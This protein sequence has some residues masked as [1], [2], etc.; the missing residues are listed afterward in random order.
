MMGTMTMYSM[1]SS[2]SA[3]HTMTST[4]RRCESGVLILS[5]MDCTIWDRSRL[6]TGMIM[7]AG[8]RTVAGRRRRRTDRGVV[9]RPS[10]P[11]GEAPSAVWDCHGNHRRVDVAGTR[12]L[13]RTSKCASNPLAGALTCSHLPVILRL[14]PSRRLSLSGTS[15]EGEG[16]EGPCL[17]SG[18]CRFP[19]P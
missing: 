6:M 15:G 5:W 8:R 7:V 3:M 13:S 12:Q 9:H 4:R 18:V 17:A 19:R 11:V 10:S 2:S 1:L 16:E 14:P